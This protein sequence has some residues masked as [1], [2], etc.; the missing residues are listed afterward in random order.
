MR[1]AAT[2]K[3]RAILPLALTLTFTMFSPSQAQE[4]IR[5]ADSENA[6]DLY[7]KVESLLASGRTRGAYEMLKSYARDLAGNPYFDYLLGVAALDSGRL[8]EAIMNLQRATAAAPEFSGARM[9][10]AR[11]HF[12]SR[13]YGT[14][15]TMFVELLAEAPPTEI[16]ELIES[17]ISAIDSRQDSPPHRFSP[18]AE[19]FSGLDSNANG[20]TDDQQFLGFTLSPENQAIDTTFFEAAAGFDWHLPRST[21]FS[22][23]VGARASYRQNPDAEFVDAGI[24]SGIASANWRSGAFFGKAAVN[25][26]GATRDG[27]SNENYGGA[28]VLFGRNIGDRWDL[29]AS[30]RSGGLRYDDSIEVL[31]VNRTLYSIGASYR[32]APQARVTF[33]LIGGDDAEQQSGSPYGNSKSGGRIALY[34]AVAESS[35]LTAS[36]GSLTS[37]YDGLFFGAS[38]EDQQDSAMLQLEFLNVGFDG[39]TLAPRIRYID[40]DS[41]VALYKYDRAEVGLLIR[42]APQ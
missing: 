37:D 6:R 5:L 16:R 35:R 21:N 13:E 1:H 2:R 36:I 18:Y 39:L 32:F 33:E 29:R 19:L 25:A 9:E 17:Y 31:D 40:N 41:D 28:E 23:F 34:A 42:W 14:A 12:E 8:S 4:T 30:L 20:S 3:C 27:N 22:W 24:L 38:R 10:L 26:Y 7:Q 11:A 15:R